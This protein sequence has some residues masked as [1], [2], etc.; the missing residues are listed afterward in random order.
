MYS[1]ELGLSLQREEGLKNEKDGRDY[2]DSLK[3]N[4]DLEGGGG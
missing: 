3:R 2:K 4:E 1:R